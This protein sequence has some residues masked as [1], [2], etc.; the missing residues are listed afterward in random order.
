[1]LKAAVL[2]SLRLAESKCLYPHSIKEF[3][4]SYCSAAVK[5]RYN[6]E[7]VIEG[8]KERAKNRSAR[9]SFCT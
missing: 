9:V 1:M 6:D 3:I 4:G 5:I 8:E 7:K 2:N